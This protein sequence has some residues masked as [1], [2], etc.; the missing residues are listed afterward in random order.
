MN[1]GTW[2]MSWAGVRTVATLELRQRVRSTRWVVALVVWFV[3]VGAITALTTGA[4]GALAGQQ[5]GP[6]HRGPLLFSVVTFLVLGLGLL[7]TPT[8]SSTAVNGDRAAGTLAT[9]QVTLLTPAE[10]AT[11]KLLAAFGA[12]GAFLVASLPF[13]GVAMAMG[14]TSVRTLLSVLVVTAVILAA[15]CGIGIG[16]SALGA[17]TAGSTVLTFLGVAGLAVFTLVF[18]GL[19]L[20]TATSH[21]QVRVWGVPA[22]SAQQCESSAPGDTSCSGSA[23][24]GSGTVLGDGPGAG[25][26]STV[27]A[28]VWR[29]E[30][31]DVVHTER[32]WWLL[33]ANPFVVV[34][35][36]S[37]V[38]DG[39]L[40]T[41]T[42]PFA[43]IRDG[44]RTARAGATGV[45]NECWGAGGPL[46]LPGSTAT[47]STRP[48]W[49]WGLGFIVLLGAAGYVTAVR[50]LRIPQRTL[51]R[52]VRVA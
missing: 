42:S 32:T 38:P 13:Y 29:A 9:V 26:S 16:F 11:G 47:P 12:A 51:A 50:R 34:A 19:T 39:D 30:T 5:S 36:A 8:L 41:A 46:A 15:V 21:E 10:I 22:S 6:L 3:V 28:C 20:P 31:R 37:A 45:V 44:V 24:L 2:R 18:F 33:A 17:R 7:V 43:A 49:P 25:G 35:D 1:G 48:V 40:A 14:G 23:T 4:L 52:G 27:P